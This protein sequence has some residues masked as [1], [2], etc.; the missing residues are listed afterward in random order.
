[1]RTS[2]FH[3]SLLQLILVLLTAVSAWGR[4]LPFT[5]GEKLLYEVRWEQIP[6][7]QLTLE[8][9]PFRTI[10]GEP[11]YHFVFQAKT[12]PAL[13][14]LYPVEGY[15]EAF[16]DQ[17]LTRS[18]MLAK[19]MQEGRSRRRY[20][21]NFDWQRGVALYENAEHKQRRIPLAAGTLD[22]L[23]ILYY[24][25]SLP[26]VPGMTVSRPLSSGKKIRQTRAHVAGRET[27]LVD[28]RPWQ[29]LR[30]VADVRKADGIF[31]KSPNARLALWLSADERKIPL[32]VVSEV[33]VGAFIIE[34]VNTPPPD[35]H[36]A[37]P[38]SAG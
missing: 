27:V 26:L 16:A 2:S 13:D 28:G 35:P 11:A 20:Q 23:S 9:R 3:Q 30:I 19:N 25:R 22:M 32:K 38:A 10:Q 18:L 24:A 8:V 17:S 12:K 37:D 6:V 4:P 36:H 29:A 5:P 15:I 21:V 1:M 7:A 34:L 31:K 33:W 14:V